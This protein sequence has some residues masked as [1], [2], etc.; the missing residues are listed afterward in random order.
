[1]NIKTFRFKE[2]VTF[3]KKKKKENKGYGG[4]PGSGNVKGEVSLRKDTGC[5]G[6]LAHSEY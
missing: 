4:A 2:S 3:F 1:M 6:I 5:V